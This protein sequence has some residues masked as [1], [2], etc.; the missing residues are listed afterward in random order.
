MSILRTLS[1][2]KNHLLL[3]GVVFIGFLIFGFSEN[4]KGPALPRLQQDF[5]F[6]EMDLG[7]LL[8][9]NSLGYLLACSFTGY[10]ADKLGIKLTSVLAFGSMAASGLLI[11]WSVNAQFFAASY[12][13]MYIGN[14][15]LEIALAI[16]A[17]RI[18]VTNTGTMMNLAHFFYGLSSAAA[19]VAA[20]SLM[21]LHVSGSALGWRGMYLVMLALS[22]LPMLPALFARFPQVSDRSE[23]RTSFA[24]YIKDPVAWLIVVILSFG[25]I[26]ELAVGAWLVNYVEKVYDWEPSASAGMLSAFFICFMLARLILGPV[27][28]RFGYI[29]SII[30]FSGLS[31]ICTW[32][33]ILLKE[34]GAFLFALAGI[35][36]APVYPTVMAFLAKRYPNG[37]G[38]AI[39][40]T[41]TLMGVFGVL[42]NF[43]IGTVTDGVKAY[44]TGPRGP[45]EGLV[46]GLKAGYGLIGLCALICSLV[47]L[48]LYL[49]LK[50]RG[51]SIQ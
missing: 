24:A 30:V 6:D 19:P 50:K 29:P 23:E 15:M 13:V 45:E 28:D 44:F 39:T 48:F 38:T 8:S 18:F 12:F 9:L 33:A 51:E 31:G 25:V 36:I 17:A 1:H 16:L 7:L 34:S 40:F 32:L 3:L 27:T 49:F 5:G 41:V 20:S 22:V 42:G 21:G 10:L 35:G 46:L 11:Y 14:G 37:T 2:R 43:L 26:S 47:S 4:V